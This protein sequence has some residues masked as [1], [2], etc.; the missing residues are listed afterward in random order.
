MPPAFVGTPV[1]SEDTERSDDNGRTCSKSSANTAATGG[2]EFSEDIGNGGDTSSS[3][4]SELSATTTAS[5]TTLLLAEASCTKLR[6]WATMVS[7]SI[8]QPS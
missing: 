7:S 5:T 6:S 3:L 4:S 1:V 8:K 2:V